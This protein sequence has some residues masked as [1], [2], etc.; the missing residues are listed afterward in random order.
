MKGKWLRLTEEKNA[1]DYL[2]KASYYIRETE[3]S[4]FAWK[5]VILALFG[6]LYG[7]LICA[8]KGTSPAWVTYQT[9]KGER[10]ISF[11]TALKICQDPNRM[12]IKVYSKPLKLSKN[13]KDSIEK[14][15]EDFRNY[16]EHYIP[17]EWS[18]EVHGMPQI[19]IDVL[20]VIR[21]LA[22]ETGTF[23]DLKKS[24]RKIIRSIVFQG[25]KI[26]RQSLLYT[27]AR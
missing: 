1:L 7:F 26:L 25:K 15:H 6:A 12:K 21:F 8:S 23:T 20:D 22:L 5:W 14:L 18:I 17:T 3:K 11:D 2:E 13:Q 10:L 27:E 9:K 19:A 24:Q 16:F 4:V